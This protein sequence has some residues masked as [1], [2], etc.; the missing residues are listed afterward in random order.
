MKKYLK[1]AMEIAAGQ[2][3]DSFMVETSVDGQDGPGTGG[4][5]TGGGGDAKERD[6]EFEAFLDYVANQDKNTNLW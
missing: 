2:S 6:E 1:P 4:P 3:T 5:S